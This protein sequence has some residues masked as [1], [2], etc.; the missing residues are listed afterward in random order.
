MTALELLEP[1]SDTCLFLADVMQQL[2]DTGSIPDINSLIERH[3]QACSTSRERSGIGCCLGFMQLAHATQYYAT[4][5]DSRF[6][7]IIEFKR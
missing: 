3:Q 4:D 6:W 5:F 1:S 7:I 2:D